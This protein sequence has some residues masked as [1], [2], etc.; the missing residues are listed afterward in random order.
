MV[1]RSSLGECECCRMCVLACSC[2]HLRV[3]VHH[4]FPHSYPSSDAISSHHRPPTPPASPVQSPPPTSPINSSIK[5]SSFSTSPPGS[6]K[7]YSSTSSQHLRVTGARLASFRR[8][9][10]V[11]RRSSSDSGG[12]GGGGTGTVVTAAS[13]GNG[14][15]GT[16]GDK[17][18]SPTYDD[19]GGTG[20]PRLISR[21]GKRNIK[22]Q[23]R[24]S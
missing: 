4:H 7:F 10:S 6:V 5:S 14:G 2:Q 19:N 11:R 18:P 20:K 13:A 8:H 15:G 1:P 24:F 23:V 21:M 17:S 9:S 22:A 16:A 12:G 3:F